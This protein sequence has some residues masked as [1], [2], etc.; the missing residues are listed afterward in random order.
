[1]FCKTCGAQ[2]NE[3]QAV[4][5]SCGSAVNTEKANDPNTSDKDWLVTLLTC[6]F[7]GGL[8]IHRFYAG[9]TGTGIIW[10]LTLG[11]FGL[12]TLIDFIQIICGK[13]TDSNGKVIKKQ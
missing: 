6:F 8:G 7:V 11:L 2:I 4:C 13:F 9:K 10:L 5:L 3:N 12:G 1:M